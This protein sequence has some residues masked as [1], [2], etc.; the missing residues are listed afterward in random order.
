M[1]AVAATP[2]VVT[3]ND[4]PLAGSFYADTLHSPTVERSL[5][6]TI[7][8][9]QVPRHPTSSLANRVTPLWPDDEETGDCF[10]ADFFTFLFRAFGA[11]FERIA[12]CSRF[13]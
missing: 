13:R 10:L 7:P 2:V 9:A 6:I 5:S 8:S 12:S 4:P 3:A 1:A 11:L